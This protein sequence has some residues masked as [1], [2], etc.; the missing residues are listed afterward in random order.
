[1]RPHPPTPRTDADTLTDRQAA[2]VRALVAGSPVPDGFDTDAVTAAARALLHKRAAEVARRF[3]LL[4]HACNDFTTRF[5]AWAA[6]NPKTSTTSDATAFAEYAG[7]DPPS[8]VKP[9]RR[10]PFRRNV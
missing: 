1:M 7:I 5:T 9:R 10:I 8:G 6:N 3:P 2:L 4:A